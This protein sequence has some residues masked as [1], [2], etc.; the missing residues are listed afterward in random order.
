MVAMCMLMAFFAVNAFELA[1]LLLP[2]VSRCRL[3]ERVVVHCS[4]RWCHY[5]VTWLCCHPC[6]CWLFSGLCLIVSN[7]ADTQ[8]QK[9]GHCLLL[10]IHIVVIDR[11]NAVEVDIALE[12]Y[13]VV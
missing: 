1:T 6:L 2:R 10:V 11:L 12:A 3:C 5:Y 8:E 4:N 13:A 9:L 7:V